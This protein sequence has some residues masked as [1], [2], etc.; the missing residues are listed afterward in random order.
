MRV[1]KVYMTIVSSGKTFFK[2]IK[3]VLLLKL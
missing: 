3:V 1:V 2:N